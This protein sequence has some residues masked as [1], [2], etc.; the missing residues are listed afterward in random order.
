MLTLMHT[1]EDSSIYDKVVSSIFDKET[2]G[3]ENNY[4]QTGGLK[5]SGDHGSPFQY[6]DLKTEIRDHVIETTKEVFKQHCAKHLEII[7][8]HLSGDCPQ[9]KMYSSLKLFLS[10]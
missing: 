4:Q 9:F 1:S 3:T 6:A 8:L 2:I 10:K 5:I 7:P